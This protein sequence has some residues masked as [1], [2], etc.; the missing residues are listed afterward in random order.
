MLWPLYPSYHFHFFLLGDC[1]FIQ[2]Y[3]PS[4]ALF[5]HLLQDLKFFPFQ[6]GVLSLVFF[7]LRL[8]QLLLSWSFKSVRPLTITGL[9]IAYNFKSYIC[10]LECFFWCATLKTSASS[11]SIHLK[12]S[13]MHWTGNCCKGRKYSS[14]NQITEFQFY[15]FSELLNHVLSWKGSS[16]HTCLSGWE[17]YHCNYIWPRYFVSGE[18]INVNGH[19]RPGSCLRLQSHLSGAPSLS[20]RCVDRFAHYCFRFICAVPHP[21]LLHRRLT[22]H[23]TP[24]ALKSCSCNFCNA[25]ASPLSCWGSSFSDAHGV[26][27]WLLNLCKELHF[28]TSCK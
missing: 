17:L 13:N 2:I 23:P 15:E 8:K 27:V 16:E 5:W 25:E 9:L 26:W 19:G 4:C 11:L 6:A 18:C 21:S 28:L 20:P 12:F 22:C 7:L 24:R 10:F 3:V 1:T 14:L